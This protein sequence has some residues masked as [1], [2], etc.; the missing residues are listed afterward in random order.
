MYLQN[1]IFKKSNI[2]NKRKEEE[3]GKEPTEEVPYNS[4]NGLYI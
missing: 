1:P 4:L 3:S 2:T